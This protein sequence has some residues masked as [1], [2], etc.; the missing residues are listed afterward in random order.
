MREKI[1]IESIVQPAASISSETSL[2]S[3]V[4]HFNEN[5]RFSLVA[6]VDDENRVLGIVMRHI[7]LEMFSRPY[8]RELFGRRPVSQYLDSNTIIVAHDTQL[9][10]VSQQLTADLDQDLPQDFVITQDGHYIGI[11]KTHTLLKRITDQRLLD[12]HHANPLTGLPGN[13]TIN[14]EIQTKLENKTDFH[15][16]YFDLDHFKP[17]NDYYGFARGDVVIQE[18]AKVLQQ[19]IGKKDFLGH[20]GGDDFVA[21][22]C[23]GNVEKT[24]KKITSAFDSLKD[25]FY[26]PQDLE[27][28]YIQV[29]DR[30]GQHQKFR[31]MGLSI[32]LAHPDVSACKNYH[33]VSRLCSEAKKQ[34]KKTKGSSVF[35]SRRRKWPGNKH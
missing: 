12:A 2:E 10:E 1:L 22:L 33:E 8:I 3:V 35:I 17:F 26:D 7:M 25:Q 11:A 18:T 6:V 14:D 20:V 24:C 5:K 30:E 13:V 19:H 9:E 34:A 15:I 16:A 31:L 28:G 21:L 4:A 23:S 29:L 32:G 27:R